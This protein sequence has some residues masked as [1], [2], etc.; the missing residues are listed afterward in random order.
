MLAK[1]FCGFHFA[2]FHIT[3]LP[4][5]ALWRNLGHEPMSDRQ[6]RLG[7]WVLPL[8]NFSKYRKVC[9]KRW[10]AMTMP[11]THLTGP[12]G[13]GAGK[14]L[15]QRWQCW[16][17]R[18]FATCLFLPVIVLFLCHP[19]SQHMLNYLIHRSFWKLHTNRCE[20]E[21]T[22]HWRSHITEFCVGV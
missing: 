19:C 14:C 13:L 7:I 5:A 10:P 21:C 16:N 8:G 17:S 9:W 3:V 18:L 4:N 2:L 11:D 15:F 1:T 20:L 22:G 12:T 6:G